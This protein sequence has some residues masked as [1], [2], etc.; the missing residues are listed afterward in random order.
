MAK[1]FKTGD[2]VIW[3]SE[4]GHV[5]GKIIKVHTLDV[6]YKEHIHRVRKVDA[7][8]DHWAAGATSRSKIHRTARSR[9]NCDNAYCSRSH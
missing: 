9:R 3:N 1:R 2:H 8:I 6:D 4:A 5:S 7:A